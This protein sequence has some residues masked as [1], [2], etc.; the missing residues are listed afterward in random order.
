LKDFTIFGD[1]QDEVYDI[2]ELSKDPT[3]ENVKKYIEDKSTQYLKDK[4]LDGPLKEKGK[5]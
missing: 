5:K 1:I 4:L 2:I 3:P